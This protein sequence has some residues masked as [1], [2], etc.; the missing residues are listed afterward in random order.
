MARKSFDIEQRL[1]AISEQL[2]ALTYDVRI[3]KVITQEQREH[4]KELR[5]A[6]HDLKHNTEDL[7]PDYSEPDYSD[8]YLDY[9][10]EN[11]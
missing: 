9:Q 2:T 1:F 3:A 6:Y 7:E 4:M 11:K 8:D 10:E 5:E